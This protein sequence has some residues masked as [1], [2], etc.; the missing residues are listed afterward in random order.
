LAQHEDGTGPEPPDDDRHRKLAEQQARR[1][2]EAARAAEWPRLI[3]IAKK[4]LAS[5]PGARMLFDEPEALANAAWSKIS[6]RPQQL[7]LIRNFGA[8]AYVLMK[9]IALEEIAEGTRTVPL[10]E[11]IAQGGHGSSPMPSDAELDQVAKW[12]IELLAEGSRLLL[13]GPPFASVDYGSLLALRVALHV[14]DHLVPEPEVRPAAHRARAELGFE[15]HHWE[16]RIHRRVA[17]V[18]DAAFTQAVDREESWG[19][20]LREEELHSVV[21]ELLAQHS[22]P[23]RP[24]NVAANL[25]YMWTFRT[26]EAVIAALVRLMGADKPTAAPPVST[27]LLQLAHRS[28]E[29]G[30]FARAFARLFKHE[31]QKNKNK[32]RG[33][34]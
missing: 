9:N 6:S 27:F 12:R 13:D 18:L 7:D 1:A 15:Q 10:D 8:Y 16:R 5:H 14:A 30:E 26:K 33:L 19:H 4:V 28:D 17:A 34:P 3:R 22:E 25:W 24:T 21:A 32:N 11:G 29:V 23:D 20:P 2:A 31:P